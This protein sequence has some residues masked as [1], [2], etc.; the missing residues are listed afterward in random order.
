MLNNN[1]FT[2]VIYNV[3]VKICLPI[4]IYIEFRSKKYAYNYK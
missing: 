4:H 1:Y 2:K 3:I